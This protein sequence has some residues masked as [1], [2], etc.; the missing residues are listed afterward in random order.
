MALIDSR[1]IFYIGNSDDP[2]VLLL[3][4]A[5][6]H[7]S[8]RTE[9]G[10]SEWDYN[11]ALASGS[12]WVLRGEDRICLNTA[13]PAFTPA[14]TLMPTL[15]EV[16]AYVTAN[17]TTRQ[18]AN[19]T[20]VSYFIPTQ[21]GNCDNPDYTWIAN[22]SGLITRTQN[23]ILT[24]AD[25][26]A[27]RALT[28][29]NHDVVAVDDFTYVGPDG[30]TYTT[31]GGIFKRDH[32]VNTFTE[33]GGTYIVGTDGTKWARDWDKLNVKPEWWV[34]GGYDSWG[35][36]FTDK[37]TISP[38][39]VIAQGQI[40]Y[41]GIRND[42][43]RIQSAINCRQMEGLVDYTINVHY[44]KRE[45]SIDKVL[46]RYNPTSANKAGTEEY[47]FATIK[48]A[49][50]IATTLAANVSIGNTT[51]TL[52]NAAN[53][54][55]GESLTI[56]NTTSPFGGLGFDEALL[57]TITNIAGNVITI[58]TASTK[59]ITAANSVVVPEI[60]LIDNRTGGDY[61]VF[62]NGIFDGNKLNNG[63]QRYTQDWRYNT[64][65]ISG[66]GSENITF[67][68]CLFRNTPAENMYMAQGFVL[69]CIGENLD[70][71][72]IHLSMNDLKYATVLT[73]GL[74]VDNCKINGVCLATNA[75]S[76][77]NEGVITNSLHTEFVKITNCTF[78]NGSES[79]FALDS[80]QPNT[81]SSYQVDNCVFENFKTVTNLLQGSTILMDAREDGLQVSN[82]RFY[83]CGGFIL[84]DF[85]ANTSIYKGLNYDQIS[86]TNNIFIGTRFYFMKCTN[87]NISGNQILFR[88]E[89]A[90]TY[91]DWGSVNIDVTDPPHSAL[92]FTGCSKITLHDN[93][94][95]NQFTDHPKL[96]AGISIPAQFTRRMKD[97]GG[98]D[99]D[100]IYE[101]GISIKNNKILGFH[102]GINGVCRP[103]QN[104]S[105]L[106]TIC[107]YQVVG[108]EFSNNTIILSSATPTV[109]SSGTI[110]FVGIAGISGTVIRDNIIYQ[111]R[112][113]N[114][115]CGIWG[116]NQAATG[117]G[118]LG[119]LIEGNMVWGRNTNFDI[120]IDAFG[121]GFNNWNAMVY[122][123]RTVNDIW[124]SNAARN[125]F[126]GN[127]R[128]N[129]TTLPG[130]TTPKVPTF[131]TFE[132][133][134]AAY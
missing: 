121:N 34:C 23:S 92:Y 130:Y 115:Q 126:A 69:N 86:I 52:T 24:V 38:D 78:K 31:R 21:G 48:R 89:T 14:N 18:K 132:W 106:P 61:V 22:S 124:T 125:H 64:S 123:N 112:A 57:V 49:N 4:P 88:D 25:Y 39:A 44:E 98:V 32:T 20:I 55:V 73:T 110:K 27:L 59:A 2:N 45:Y 93:I 9:D 104:V 101:Q 122:N 1:G 113:D 82:S 13:S 51:I 12:R 16:T 58:S 5:G 87:I 3:E 94:I 70:G 36:I 11:G 74:H 53:Y 79:I 72:F 128:I 76:G 54:F 83:N 108:W 99:T 63:G 90:S 40:F 111:Q 41:A 131:Q 116:H 26:T 84:T 118:L 8:C 67:Q 103:H 77:H 68:N 50:T 29:Y 96:V 95:E 105:A 97:A 119:T 65:V 127:T 100:F 37:N 102:S 43:D 71:S 107:T 33:N 91:P 30:V 129:T 75:I 35:R 80:Q 6:L 17:L 109:A 60:T 81:K 85:H 114:N 19:G 10:N 62:N 47:N 56:F 66:T 28:G 117:T 46:S 133:N 7:G 15:A 42:R 134:K 120:T